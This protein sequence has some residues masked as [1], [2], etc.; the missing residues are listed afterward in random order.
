MRC[1]ASS[2][3]PVLALLLA[4]GCDSDSPLQLT[5]REI[6]VAFA[7]AFGP[8]QAVVV[9]YDVWP[10][11]DD[12]D[13]NGAPDDVTGDG[14]PDVS[15]WCQ[16]TARKGTPVPWAYSLE[17]KRIRAGAVAAETLTSTAAKSNGQNLTPYDDSPP[18]AVGAAPGNVVLDLPRGRCQL[19]KGIKCNPNGG[20]FVNPCTAAAAGNCVRVC[21]GN[22]FTTC[23]NDAQC[24]VVGGTCGA[25]ETRTFVFDQA[26]AQRLAA[27]APLFNG[28]TAPNLLA[29]LCSVT[30][31]QAEGV[32]F[33][34][35]ICPSHSLGQPRLDGAPPPFS[36]FL[37]A[38]DTIIVEARRFDGAP[39]A[40]GYERENDNLNAINPL[41]ALP[42]GTVPN[43]ILPSVQATLTVDGTAILS[44]AL[45]G[46]AQIPPNNTNSAISFSYQVD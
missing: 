33:Q 27:S 18:Q 22:D 11:Y 6:E 2:S 43:S 39:A 29:Q 1:R 7:A 38:G 23:T 26:G 8:S 20:T 41:F 10:F 9:E 37:D 40:S 34:P 25:P 17:I 19:K 12:S 42:G 35:G 31:C 24:A 32:D 46:Q 3:L 15:L 13:G 44:S 30:G 4:A 21:S 16:E 36:I 45:N 5:G 28:N 14:V